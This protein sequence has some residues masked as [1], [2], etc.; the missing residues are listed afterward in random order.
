MR[1]KSKIAAILKDKSGVSLMFVLGVMMFLLAIGAS[2]LAAASAN[3]GANVRQNEYNRV[4]VLG[5]SIHR[6]I[7]HSLQADPEDENS[8]ANRLAWIVYET[9]D[10]VS[11]G[12]IELELD[13]DTTGNDS[14]PEY[15]TVTVSLSFLNREVLT[16]DAT[17]YVPEIPS[18]VDS[19]GITVEAVPEVPRMPETAAISADMLVTVVIEADGRI[20]D[21]SRFIST[22]A[23]YEYRGGLLTDDPLGVY[24]TNPNPPPSLPLE[25]ATDGF[26]TWSMIS[27]EII[28]SQLDNG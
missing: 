10:I 28:E 17:G 27:Y 22:Q 18:F 8:L 11:Q 9:P 3:I 20:R 5:D 15:M 12:S 19:D 23:V 26:G 14:V 25:F 1:L 21:G 16:T 4:I 2:L 6:S 7:M 24:A 13:F